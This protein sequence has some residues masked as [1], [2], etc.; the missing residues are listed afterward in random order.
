MTLTELRRKLFDPVD[1]AGLAI[2]RI[3]FGALMCWDACR[4]VMLG[5][6]STHYIQPELNLKF[7]G[8]HWVGTLPGPL[9]YAVF[10]VMV[11]SSAAICI[12]AHY[13]L[14]CLLFFLSHTYVFLVAAEYYLNHAYLISTVA[15]LLAAHPLLHGWQRPRIYRRCRR[16]HLLA[17]VPSSGHPTTILQCELQAVQ[18]IRE[19]PT[20]HARHRGQPC[21][22]TDRPVGQNDRSMLLQRCATYKTIDGESG[23]WC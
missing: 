10:G 2:F 23:R 15:F 7:V 14:S 17:I 9:M 16:G 4:Y 11:A 3:A 6:V 21:K 5:W 13:R 22:V 20:A 8:F 18:M 1:V 19:Q 12:G